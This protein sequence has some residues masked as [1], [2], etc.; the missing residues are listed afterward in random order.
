MAKDND[1]TPKTS[2]PKE[3]PVKTIRPNKT[4]K[5]REGDTPG[6][7]RDKQS[8]RERLDRHVQRG[9]VGAAQFLDSGFV[10]LQDPTGYR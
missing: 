10:T 8:R 6:E 9:W 4:I 1:K 7:S 3:Q 2:T 5:V